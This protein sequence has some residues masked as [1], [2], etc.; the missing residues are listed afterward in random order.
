MDRI[1]SS[2]CARNDCITRDEV[3]CDP[4]VP[5]AA[6]RLGL[7]VKEIHIGFCPHIDFHN[8]MHNDCLI[9]MTIL[10]AI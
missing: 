6:T 4:V 5:G 9:Y 1:T 8:I 10:F 7:T 3:E 2:G